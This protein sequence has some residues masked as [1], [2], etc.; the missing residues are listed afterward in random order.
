MPEDR[1]QKKI[2]TPFEK[3][4]YVLKLLKNQKNELNLEETYQAAKGLNNISLDDTRRILYKIVND[5]Y[6]FSNHSSVKGVL[7]RISFNGYLFQGYE[8]QAKIDQSLARRRNVRD[9]VLS[10]GTALAGLIGL[11]LL[12]WQVYL[13]YHSSQTGCNINF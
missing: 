1:F 12:I 10:W 13:Y 2:Y 5:G 9:F 6:A 7:Y 4:D 8:K 3:L 11:C